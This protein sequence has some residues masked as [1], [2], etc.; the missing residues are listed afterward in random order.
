MQLYLRLKF[1][2]LVSSLSLPLVV[3][4]RRPWIPVGRQTLN[5]LLWDDSITRPSILEGPF[6]MRPLTSTTWAWLKFDLTVTLLG[7][8]FFT[9]S[10]RRHDLQASLSFCCF[11]YHFSGIRVY[12]LHDTINGKTETV[13]DHVCNYGALS[14]SSGHSF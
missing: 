12:A 13:K 14:H 3:L 5:N 6:W 2:P 7:L 1:P 4:V 8:T 9:S 10:V 11:H